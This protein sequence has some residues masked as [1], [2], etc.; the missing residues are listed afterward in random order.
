M[1]GV[2]C[3]ICCNAAFAAMLSLCCSLPL[4]SMVTCVRCIK[5]YSLKAQRERR[6]ETRTMTESYEECEEFLL[7]GANM[8]VDGFLAWWKE[9]HTARTLEH[10]L[11]I[12][13]RNMRLYTSRDTCR[14]YA[15]SIHWQL[16]NFLRGGGLRAYALYVTLD[17]FGAFYI[18]YTA[19]AL[20][21]LQIFFFLPKTGMCYGER[22]RWLYT[23]A[24]LP[25]LR[26]ARTCSDGHP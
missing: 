25:R 22:R 18:L 13:K 6:E 7:Q 19:Q 11:T 17:L 26:C 14:M 16:D 10:I 23:V 15:R 2:Q 4:A 5:F 12:K 8:D 3:C 20:S 21:R 1:Y 24:S 9:P